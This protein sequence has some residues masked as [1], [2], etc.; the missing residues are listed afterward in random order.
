M[1]S[2]GDMLKSAREE[3]GFTMDQAIHET[4]ISR[5]YLEALENE[6]FDEFPAEAYLV[7]FL[8]NYSEYLGLD[9]ERVVG[10]FKNYKLSEQPTPIEQLV[11]PPKGAAMKKALPWIVLAI[12]VAAL[13]VFGVPRLVT[14]MGT[15][16]EAR[17][18]RA[19]AAEAVSPVRELRPGAALW[20]SEVRP[21]DI[22]ILENN[23]DEL[24]L[25]VGSEGG[26]LFFDGGEEGS[27]SLMLG[28]E[29]YLPG[30]DGR[31]L[32]RLYVKDLGLEAGGGI[33]EVQ[34]LIEAGADDELT[35][36]AL[37][38]EPP[39]G[40]T[41]RRRESRVVLSSSTPDRFTI[42]VAF[43]DFCLFRYKADG[44]ETR[45]TYYANGDNFRLDVGRNVTIWA[46]NAGALYT[47]IGGNELPL[48][49]R[50][51]VVAGVI[52]WVLNEESGNYDLTFL[53][54]Y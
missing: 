41:E 43:R 26:R 22:I 25:T 54:I 42:D 47:K 31:P 40:E 34:R 1:K 20:E 33:L 19:R 30:P 12:A 37:V 18:E 21:S 13:G 35:V 39:S 44:Q 24:R 32:W 9:A 38:S 49:R 52:R 23:G 10:Q 8:R 16:R 5:S 48:G 50:G 3:R 29:L 11:G 51:E 53:P 2:L 27:W 4:N 17:E 6:D 15:M 46:S 7:G 14:L 28:E 36:E 45:E